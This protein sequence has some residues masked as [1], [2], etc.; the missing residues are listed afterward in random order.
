MPDESARARSAPI[1]PP[2]RRPDEP[3]RSRIRRL[4]E[5]LRA[6]PTGRIVLRVTVGIVG[7]LVVVTGIVLL[8]LPGPGWAIIFVGIAV[9]AIEFHWARRLLLFA[10]TQVFQWR[11]WYAARS[12]PLKILVG[13]A[14]AIVVAAIVLGALWLSVGPTLL[15][16]LR[17]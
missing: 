17:R 16:L 10:K 13:T 9:W 15:H 6:H 11:T 4:I 1:R 14:L 3:Q 7:A 12:L 2:E 8:P 5:A